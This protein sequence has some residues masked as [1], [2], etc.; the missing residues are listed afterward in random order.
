MQGDVLRSIRYPDMD[1]GGSRLVEG[2][3]QFVRRRDFVHRQP[4]AACHRADIA[5]RRRSKETLE[6]LRFERPRLWQE[7]EDPSPAVVDDDERATSL[8]VEV[9][10]A[11]D[12][13][14]EGQV[15]Q[16]RDGRARGG[17]HRGDTEG[18]RD[19]AVD[20][21]GPT[22]GQHAGRDGCG[23]AYHSRSRMGM[24]ADTTTVAPLPAA[25]A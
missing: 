17:R 23:A 5:A 13:V 10:Q 14:E 8:E 6:D 16:E 18:R 19:N 24:D 1:H 21:V 12:V 7:R 22:V 2:G 4:E 25:W 3:L 15:T 20:A 9:D 11:R